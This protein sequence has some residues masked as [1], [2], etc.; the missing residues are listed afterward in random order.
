M[1][2]LHN[3]LFLPEP[4]SDLPDR[5]TNT[6]DDTRILELTDNNYNT[7][8]DET[9]ITVNIADAAGDATDIDLIWLKWTG[10][11][12]SYVATPTGGTGSALTRT[13]PNS[14]QN[15]DGNTVPLKFDGFSHDLY[16]ID[17]DFSGTSLQLEFTG[18]DLAIVDLMILSDGLEFRSN[19]NPSDFELFDASESDRN[20]LVD[21]DGA[22]EISRSDPALST[23]LTE[24]SRPKSEIP[25]AIKAPMNLHDKTVDEILDWL[26]INRNFVFVR[27]FSRYP[28]QVYRACVQSLRIEVLPRHSIYKG[29]G[30]IIEFTIVEQ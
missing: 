19:E 24:D 9:D 4:L 17:S 27:E 3:T 5:I 21:V 28:E 30:E 14:I 10:T 18:T 12:T 13:V 8:S 15:F 25:L 7:S 22:G 11:L 26:E 6:A 29:A 2:N 23:F 20:A 16:I 1:A